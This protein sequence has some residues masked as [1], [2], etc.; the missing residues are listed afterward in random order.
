MTKLPLTALLLVAVA[1]PARGLETLDEACPAVADFEARIMR[2]GQNE[3]VAAQ[4]A[5]C[6]QEV[7]ASW[8]AA[9]AALL[10]SLQALGKNGNQAA[11]EADSK[12]AYKKALQ[13]IEA[14]VATM[15]L[16]TARLEQYPLAMIDVPGSSG[17]EDSLDCFNEA[18]HQ[19]QKTI[20][21]LDGEIIRAKKTYETTADMMDASGARQV[22]LA[23]SLTRELS[24]AAS[25][26]AVPSGNSPRAS[27]T[28]TG[29]IN[30]EKELSSSGSP[31]EASTITAFSDRLD[32]RALARGEAVGE[33]AVKRAA[34]A[35]VVWGSD[36]LPA[37]NADGNASVGAVLWKENGESAGSGKVLAF[38]VAASA[39]TGE[40]P[41]PKAAFLSPAGLQASA[42]EQA[43]PAERRVASAELDLFALVRSKYRETELFRASR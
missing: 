34:K 19:V 14:Q 31:E 25:P 9:S 15:Q 17:D 13:T 4:A 6:A 35:A 16:Y 39:F 43:S 23:D 26:K 18:F 33:E 20:N 42:E 21:F 36:G 11:S 12:L 5:Y 2:C 8:N 27:S 28:I 22:A 30:T 7:A 10:P 38:G 1:A 40:G 29:K 37:G 41:S 3:D 32:Q 24:S